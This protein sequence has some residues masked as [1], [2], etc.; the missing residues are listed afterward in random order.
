MNAALRFLVRRPPRTGWG[1]FGLALLA[2]LM[3]ASLVLDSALEVDAGPIFAAVVLGLVL[4][5]A[6]KGW[7]RVLLLAIALAVPLLLLG[8]APSPRVVIDDLRI[9][10]T[11]NSPRPPFGL[12]GALQRSFTRT[13]ITLQAAWQ[14]DVFGLNWAIARLSALLSYVAALVLGIGLRR[15]ARPLLYVLPLLAAIAAVG[16]TVR[17]GTFHMLLVVFPALLVCVVGDFARREHAWEQAGIDFSALLR[18]DVAALGAALAAAGIVLGLLTPSAARNPLTRR[19]WTDLPLPAGLARLDRSQGGSTGSGSLR[20]GG[21][22]PGQDL[23]LGRSLEEAGSEEIALSIRAPGVDAT[24]LPYWRG[25]IL[26]EYTGHGWTTGPIRSIVAAPLVADPLPAGLVV[27]QVTDQRTGRQLRYGLPDIVALDTGGTYEQDTAGATASWIGNERQYTV[28]SSPPVALSFE[29]PVAID[30]QRMLENYLILPSGLPQR[31]V[32]LAKQLTANTASRTAQ[33][34][35]IEGYLRGLNYSYEVAPLPAG[36]DAVD[37]FLFEMRTGYCTY[38]ASAMALMARANGI[39]SRIATGYATGEYDAA[40][41][42]FVVREA[43]AHAWPELYIDGQGWTRWEPTP[44]RPLPARSQASELPRP[45]VPQPQPEP[46][47]SG[48]IWWPVVALGGVFAVVLMFA[49]VRR[50]AMPL[51]PAGVHA[52]LYRWGRHAGVPPRV[53]DS[54]EQYAARLAHSVPAIKQP[55]EQVAR[56]LTARVYRSQP[57]DPDEERSLINAWNRVRLI[58][59]RR[60]E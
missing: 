50:L 2:V 57:L 59:G 18:S 17:A 44:V 6:G 42:R 43:D 34:E 15:G 58:L 32:D 1:L 16:I 13:L 47:A 28:Y 26:D 10:L 31:V 46:A 41:D 20:L 11:I 5:L 4:G 53:A 29:G 49:R 48:S 54:I 37:Q 38:Y 30:S 12:P 40:S 35:A 3:L 19:I 24:T 14:G 21:T 9:L 7:R 60:R 56:L 8:L 33:A 36:G 51:T 45:F 23:E 52:D 25:R 22:R 27:Q 39:P 55:V